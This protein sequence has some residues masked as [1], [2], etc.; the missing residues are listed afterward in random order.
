MRSLSFPCRYTN[1]DRVRFSR[2]C[3]GTGVNATTWHPL[4]DI[5]I[6]IDGAASPMVTFEPTR[7]SPVFTIRLERVRWSC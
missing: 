1:V 3:F 5:D 7:R 6:D 2:A 4:A